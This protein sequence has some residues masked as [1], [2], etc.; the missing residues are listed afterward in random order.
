[1]RPS[2]D[3]KAFVQARAEF[4]EARELPPGTAFFL[5]DGAMVDQREF[6]LSGRE[7]TMFFGTDPL[8]T[9]ETTLGDKKTGEKG[10]FGQKQSFVRQWTL[11]V[12]N[13]SARPVQVRIEEP[14]PLPRDER[15]TLELKAKPEPLTE[16]DPEIMAWNAT[17]P[18]G[19]QSVV[20]LDLKMTAP[21]D[22]HVDP[23]WRW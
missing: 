23:G 17:V 14:R 10:L 2:L 16:D 7:G 1:M 19:G 13:A 8:L 3:T 5:L 18:A 11:T 15:I 20:E 21:E 22:L 9:C 12:R 4:K 6:S